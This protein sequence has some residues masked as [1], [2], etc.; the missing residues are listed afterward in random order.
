M[1]R[2]YVLYILFLFTTHITFS[3]SII[4][5]KVTDSIGQ[6]IISANVLLQTNSTNTILAYDYTDQNGDFRI[7]SDNI[8]QLVLRISA[9]GYTP[10]ELQLN[11][12]ASGTI[13]KESI[14]LYNEPFALEEVIIQSD[15]PITV[16]RDT[17]VFNASSFTDGTEDVVE[18]LLKKLPGIKVS[19]EGNIT[20]QG[21]SIEKVMVEGDDLFEKGYKLLTKNLN[22][23]VISK[24]EV[25]ENF[26]D[27]PL[28]K[29][30]EDSDKVAL[31]LTIKE[32]RKSTLFGNASLGLGTRQFYENRLNLISFNKKT[33]YYLFGN[34]NNTG[35]DPTGD[36]YALLNPGL[37]GGITYIGDDQQ[38]IEFTDIGTFR[39]N[40]KDNRI[41]FNN[42]EFA[43]ING[44]Y[45]PS[46]KLKI[47]GLAFFNSDENDFF[48]NLTSNYLIGEDS[49]INTED[50][51]VKRK[52]INGFGKWD[53]ISDLS[54]RSRL[55]Y[56]GKYQIGN[57]DSFS[58]LIFNEEAINEE[59]QNESRFFDQRFTYT[60]R[61][62]D[63]KA[64]LLTGR[65]IYDS[66]PQIY[67]TDTYIFDELFSNSDD[68][69]GVLQKSTNN[70]HFLGIEGNYVISGDKTNID[71]K[72]GYSNSKN[73]LHSDFLF[74][75]TNNEVRNAGEEF[76]NDLEFL[77]DDIYANFRYRYAL[78]KLKLSLTLETHQI[79]STVKQEGERSTENP[80]YTIP[81][82]GINWSLNERNKLTALYR[83]TTTNFS[84]NQLYSNYILTDFRSFKRGTGN[85]DQLN[86]S[87]FLSNYTY[88]NWDDEFLIN[89][90]FLYQKDD[91]YTSSNSL[92]RQN[93]S[94]NETIILNDKDFYSLSVN[95]DKFINKLSS[96]IKV[97]GGVS[98]TNFENIV[99]N[100][101]LR[102][103]TTS[104]YTYGMELRSVF[105][106]MFNFHIGTKWMNSIVEIN[107]T[108]TNLN[109]ESFLDVTL[110]FS[111]KLK[112]SLTNERYYFGNLAKDNRVFYFSDFNAQYT[113]KKNTLTLKFTAQNIWN[114]DTYA[115][116]YI[117]DTSELRTEYRLL[118]R[119]FLLKMDFRF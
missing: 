32:G 44:I 74:L 15:A 66:K 94:L 106:G 68:I 10:K 75:D 26:S 112:F 108:N 70:L 82:I 63:H 105:N 13:I 45:N 34:L 86:G 110:D 22:S 67:Q 16:K 73:D 20:V 89:A 57:T 76:S 118:P 59:L 60:H 114:T 104:T 119:Y 79:I 40:L 6:P 101:E 93:F 48:S 92:I 77:L 41:N 14:Q 98:S 33:K 23:E 58:N 85:F 37:F 115:N 97:N 54:K 47:K 43:S 95:I 99:N 18:D 87:L 83:Y 21:K 62:S 24:V 91:N 69:N 116:F 80:F 71:L 28:L 55:A 81:T 61:N 50:R 8:G 51:E 35:V 42:A 25:L 11:L 88:G 102:K 5:G 39:P 19:E 103:I 3:Q 31:N 12:T 100:S 2:T 78:G 56:T 27:N 49:F 17:I 1:N 90:S 64:F 46:D 117:G 109:N 72:F 29:G 96:N 7:E 111:K 107:T 65:Y 84:L 113:I 36:I 9:L 52:S 30:I 38:A 4:K 53:V